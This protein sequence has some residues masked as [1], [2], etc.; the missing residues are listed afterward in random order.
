MPTKVVIFMDH[1][2]LLK[3]YKHNLDNFS[4]FL[5]QVWQGWSYS[6][7]FGHYILVTQEKVQRNGT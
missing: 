5:I 6:T 1:C 3:G 7:V 2:F 4:F